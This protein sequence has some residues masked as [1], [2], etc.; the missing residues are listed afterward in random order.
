MTRYLRIGVREGTLQRSRA[1]A[2]LLVLQGALSVLLLVA[3]G[4]FVRSLSKVRGLRLGY[5]VDPVLLVDVNLRGVRLDSARN[6]DLWWR[7]SEAARRVQG[8]ERA[9]LASSVPFRCCGLDDQVV[10]PSDMDSVRFFKLPD[11]TGNAVTPDYF[12]TMQT[13]ILRGRGIDSVRRARRDL[14]SSS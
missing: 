10:R 7:L 4:L 3:A 14:E 5:D 11:I 2:T 1:R 8:V 9:G 13:R 6:A 12:A